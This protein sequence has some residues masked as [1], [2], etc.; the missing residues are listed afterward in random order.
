MITHNTTSA[1][2]SNILNDMAVTV[3][4]LDQINFTWSNTHAN[5]YLNP[6]FDQCIGDI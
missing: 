3:V 1:W 2:K 6:R 5:Q 4:Y